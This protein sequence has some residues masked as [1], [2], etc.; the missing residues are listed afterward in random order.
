MPDLTGHHALHVLGRVEQHGPSSQTLRLDIKAEPDAKEVPAIAFTFFELQDDGSGQY[1]TIH[2]SPIQLAVSGGTPRV[3]PSRTP[4]TDDIFSLKS[5]S[6]MVLGHPSSST[7]GWHVLVF[8][9]GL[10]WLLSL[11]LRSMRQRR[12]RATDPA[13]QR[14]RSAQNIFLAAIAAETPDP[15][16]ALTIYLAARLDCPAAAIIS[17][18][19]GAKLA[20]AGID[21][22]LAQATAACTEQLLAF[23]YD[24]DSTSIK[25]SLEAVKSLVAALEESF[26]HK[27]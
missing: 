12:R 23:E 16:N 25:P 1:Q 8:L 4:G 27:L 17:P 5:I 7:P 3:E 21:K 20:A 22:E 14:A 9:C 15:G 2:S 26:R 10:P 6:E 18:D 11:G 19:L 13:Q 24:G